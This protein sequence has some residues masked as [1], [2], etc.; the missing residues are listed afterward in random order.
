[1]PRLTTNFINKKV[2]RP[3]KGKR[4][5]YR[6]SELTGFG[7]KVTHTSMTY[8]AEARVNGCSRRVTLG[9][10]KLSPPEEARKKALVILA[11]MAAG[12]D[13]AKEKERTRRVSLTLGEAFEE[14]IQR[15]W[16]P[17]LESEWSRGKDSLLHIFCSS[18][19]LSLQM[20]RRGILRE[21]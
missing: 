8:F 9:N 15:L 4:L 20:D 17:F 21:R 7:L 18:I 5:F 19:K 10:A 12:H 1:M 14:Y 16:F 3:E 13:P 6:D 11:K 2:Q